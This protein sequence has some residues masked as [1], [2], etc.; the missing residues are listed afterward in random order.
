MTLDL[1]S[2]LA[3]SFRTM[4]KDGGRRR[5]HVDLIEPAYAGARLLGRRL[6]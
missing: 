1:A 6:K 2:K 4:K 3:L 5:R